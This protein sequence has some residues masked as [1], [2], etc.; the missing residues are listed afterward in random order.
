MHQN[1]HTTKM[2][3]K[4]KIKRVGRGFLIPLIKDADVQFT[5]RILSFKLLHKMRE[6]ECTTGAIEI[7]EKCTQGVTFNWSHFLLNELID[8]LV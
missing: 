4:Y 5:A 1:K 3:I 8:D 2:K 6:N 7:A